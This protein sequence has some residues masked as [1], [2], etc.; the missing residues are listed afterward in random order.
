MDVY[1]VGGAV[2]DQLLGRPVKERD[3]VVVGVH[4]QDLLD[5]GYQQV[6]RDFPVFLHPK[7][8]EEYALA[9]TERKVG[10]GYKGFAFHA[11]PDVTLEK[12]LMRRDLTINA[13]AMATDGN[14]VDPHGGQHDIK[15]RVLR[16]VSAAFAEDPVRILRVARFASEL[17]DF[18][19]HPETMRLMQGMVAAGETDHLV[20]ERVWQECDKA[21]RSQ[22]PWRYF[23]VLAACGL[24]ER[25]V[26]CAPDLAALQRATLQSTDVALRWAVC[27]WQCAV[28]A[29]ESLCARWHTPKCHAAM[30]KLLATHGPALQQL[31][32]DAK[33]V[34]GVLQACD[35][36]RRPER[37]QDLLLASSV[38]GDVPEGIASYWQAALTAA[39]GIDVQ[40]MAKASDGQ[41]IKQAI[42]DARLERLGA[43]LAA[44]A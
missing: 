25:L 7:S 23:E 42:A 1:L 5:L 6:G 38:C 13:I 26:A 11:A 21:L 39:S 15:K 32:D 43:Y 31:S 28:S 4:P 2:R 17:P 19:V 9:R 27:W 20:A 34:L 12:D 40:A 44:R 35:A 18:T 37:F 16:H 10:P 33:V 22:A 41:A 29:I 36:F 8:K 24:L 30:A 3:W 14:F